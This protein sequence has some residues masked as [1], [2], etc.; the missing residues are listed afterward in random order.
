MLFLPAGPGE[1]D[2]LFLAPASV[3]SCPHKNS[4]LSRGPGTDGTSN[5]KSLAH[6]VFP[7]SCA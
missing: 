2:P 7:I 6:G 4:P 5:S 1:G 3:S